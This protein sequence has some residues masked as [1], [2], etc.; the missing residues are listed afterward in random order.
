LPIWV[1][2]G[3]LC[4]AYASLDELHQYFTPFRHPTVRDIG[5]DMLGVFIAFLWKYRYI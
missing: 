4:L 2:A 3:L 1:A 5:Y